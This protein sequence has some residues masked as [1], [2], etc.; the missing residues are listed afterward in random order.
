MLVRIAGL[1]ASVLEPFGG[2]TLP[3]ALRAL[4]ETDA[5]LSAARGAL[6]DV[7]HDVLKELPAELRGLAL[8]VR[9]DCFNGRSL[10]THRT[11]P[12]WEE[13]RG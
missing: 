9:R 8:E 10:A 11:A 2:E 12:G 4:E 5:E 1:P 7:L 3:A 13:L 6:A